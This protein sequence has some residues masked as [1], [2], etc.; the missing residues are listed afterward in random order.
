[1]R[2][3]WLTRSPAH[4]PHSSRK[5]HA[6]ARRTCLLCI[7]PY[8]HVGADGS[9]IK[10][11]AARPA[12]MP[13]AIEHQPYMGNKDATLTGNSAFLMARCRLAA[14][15][16]PPWLL[17]QA[18][19]TTQGTQWGTGGM[20]TKLTAARIATAAGCHTVICRASLPENI[21][22]VLDGHRLGTI[23]YPHPQALRWDS[24]PQC[25]AAP[26]MHCC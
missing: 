26:L 11:R 14:S 4:T 17:L 16:H 9:Q 22:R 19:T 20:A 2:S 12:R 7:R 24:Q 23:F 25:S 15:R 21:V 5:R 18:D 13:G 6:A 10:T 8:R 3:P 1:M